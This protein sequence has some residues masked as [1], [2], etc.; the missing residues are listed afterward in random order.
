MG[1]LVEILKASLPDADC[2]TDAIDYV[3]GQS[4]GEPHVIIISTDTGW[5]EDFG[6]LSYSVKV[7]QFF[8]SDPEAGQAWVREYVEIQD[9]DERLARLR[10]IHL[11]A[12][13]E[14]WV[15]PIASQSYYTLVRSPWRYHGPKLF[16]SGALWHLRHP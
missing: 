11:R 13:S 4:D 12:L 2:R 14:P 7:G 9:K 6:F 10:D 8:P 16:N 3:Y 15:V 5:T 1:H